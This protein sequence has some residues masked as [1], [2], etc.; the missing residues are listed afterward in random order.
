MHFVDMQ[1]RA[2]L[3]CDGGSVARQHDRF[4]Y[5]RRFQGSDRG[6]GLRFDLVG[7][8]DVSRVFAVD[9]GVNNRS[10][11]V[12]RHAVDVQFAHQLVVSRREFFAVDAGDN[13]ASAYFANVRN[14]RQIAFLPAR[15]PNAFTDRVR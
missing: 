13:A 12:A 15:A 3:I 2:D 10:R 11:A 8:D 5:A 4:F 7:D 1:I 14:A 6:F 9:C